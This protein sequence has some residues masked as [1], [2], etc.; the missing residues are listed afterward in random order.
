MPRTR[1]GRTCD[2]L[3]GLTDHRL[4][5]IQYERIYVCDL[6]IA[7]PKGFPGFVP[8]VFLCP[9]RIFEKTGITEPQWNC[10]TNGLHRVRLHKYIYTDCRLICN[11]YHHG[12]AGLEEGLLESSGLWR[13]PSSSL[14]FSN[15]RSWRL[16]A[17]NRRVVVTANRRAVEQRLG[18]GN[19]QPLGGG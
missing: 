13:S 2:L 4:L 18:G 6:P 5:G 7:P 3:P 17:A 12:L 8:L 15:R 1:V 14:C 19:G 11:H 10:T 16:T 9:F